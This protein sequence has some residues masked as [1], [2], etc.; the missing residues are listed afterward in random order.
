MAARDT[1]G[2]PTSEQVETLALLFN[3]DVFF[4]VKIT[5]TLKHA[6]VATRV[7]RRLTDYQQTL[8]TVV[9]G[10]VLI[11]TVRTDG[12]QDALD[13]AATAGIPSLAFGSHV[14]LETQAEARR[15]GATGVIPNSRL[16]QELP[17]ILART[18]ARKHRGARDRQLAPSEAGDE[19]S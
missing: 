11:N 12:W 9:P 10:I 14:D 13:L 2:Q 1:S 15:H 17:E 19:S 7:V 3:N 4:T 18:I 8:Q 6:G 16:T 5:E